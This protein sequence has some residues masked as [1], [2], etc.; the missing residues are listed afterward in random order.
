VDELSFKYDF[1][2][3]WEETARLAE[4]GRRKKIK[5][6]MTIQKI[7]IYESFMYPFMSK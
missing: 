5:V 3:E 4:L 1:H 6:K 2:F 7:E